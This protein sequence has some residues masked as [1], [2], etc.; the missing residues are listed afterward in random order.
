MARIHHLAIKA[1]D[2][3]SL[4]GFYRSVIGLS[5]QKRH[6]DEQGLR[7]VWLEL[8]EAILM[9]ERSED[10]GETPPFSRDPP[11]LHLLALAI[12]PGEAPDWRRRLT[13]VRET[14]YTLYLADPEGN[15]IA[16][17]SWPEPLAP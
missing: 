12:A 11:G 7:S 8:G 10:G 9:I 4:A 15:R 1:K 13:V 17:S 16:L 14:A 2:P 6:Q 5:E 3:E